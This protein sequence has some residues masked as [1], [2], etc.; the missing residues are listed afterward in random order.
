VVLGASKYT[1]PKSLRSDIAKW[2]N[3][4]SSSRQNRSF[5]AARFAPVIIAASSPHS[6][7]SL[8][9]K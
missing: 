4:N 3:V 7:N 6:I 1:R 5:L 2:Q 8:V 9:P